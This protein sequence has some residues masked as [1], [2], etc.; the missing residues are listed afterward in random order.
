[1]TDQLPLPV[2]APFTKAQRATVLNLVRRAARTEIMPRFRALD[3]GQISQKSSVT[4]LVTE[5][6]T[7][8]EALIARGLQIAFPSAVIVG[9]E[10][11]ETHTD[12]REK[13]EQ[14]ELGFLIDPIDGTWNFAHGLP[15]FGTMIAVCR[16]GRPVF[17]LIFDP[18]GNDA[19][20]ADID[21][22]STWTGV[23]GRSRRVTTR[24]RANLAQMTGIIEPNFM[25]L[26][27]RRAAMEACFDLA[28]AWTLRC[29]A[30]HYRLLAEGAVD[31]VMASKLAP[32][33]H[34]AG[35][36]LCQQA[37]GYSAMLDGTAYTTSITSGYLLSAADEA[38]W[39]RLA[40]HFSALLEP[41]E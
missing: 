29:S 33:D 27:H 22:P 6:D 20:W 38:T 39:K 2:T 32:W 5:A 40:A 41:A 13:L 11:S 8:A 25:P 37:G 12:Y 24:A 3:A 28:H 19:I 1:M 15:L 10:M 30:H 21:T 14:A 7:S 23:S 9:E 4:D 18:I 35:V 31:F 36:M 16:F 34:A 26:P 17:G